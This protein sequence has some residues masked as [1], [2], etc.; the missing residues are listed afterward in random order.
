M[1]TEAVSQFLAMLAV[2]AEVAAVTAVVLAVG[3]RLSPK[4]R[5]LARQ[6]VE[7]VAPSALSMAAVVAAVATA[8]SLYY[9]EVAHFPPCPLCWYQRIA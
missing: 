2:L 5:T 9:S 1:T 4:L 3:S 8:G 7:A 6:T